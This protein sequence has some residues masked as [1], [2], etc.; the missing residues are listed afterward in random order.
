M[1]GQAELGISIG[2]ERWGREAFG[3]VGTSQIAEWA[4]DE[5]SAA[6]EGAGETS[7]GA[8]DGAAPTGGGQPAATDGGEGR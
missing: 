2:C 4:L 6:G 5:T 7:A 3:E 8:R 1:V